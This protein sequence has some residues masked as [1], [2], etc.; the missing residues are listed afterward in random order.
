M[1]ESHKEK[2]KKIFEEYEK[3]INPDAPMSFRDMT[4]IVI[5]IVGIHLD[6]E[7]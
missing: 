7:L 4:M 2:L 5:D 6:N 1:S 3:T